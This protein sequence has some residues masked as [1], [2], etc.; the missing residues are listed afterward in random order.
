MQTKTAVALPRD[1]DADLDGWLEPFLDATGRKTRRKM[2]PLYVRGLLGGG[3]R[4]S[5]QPMAERLGLPGHDQLHH[6]ISSSAWD[7]APLWRGLA[8]Q[9]DRAGGGAGAVLMGDDTGLPKTGELSVGGAPQY[10]GAGGQTTNCQGLVS[11][12]LARGEVPVPVGLQ[13]FVPAAWSNDLERCA[14]A[15]VPDALRAAR[16]KPA[17]ALAEID[18]LIAAGVRF[19]CVLA[20]AGYGASPDFRRGLDRR[21]LAWA[22]GVACPQ[23]VYPTTVRL[24][25]SLTPTGRPAK[26]PVPSRLPGSVAALLETQRWQRITWRSGSKGPL[27]ARFAALRVRVADGPRNADNTRLPGDGRGHCPGR[28]GGRM[29]RQRRE[30]ILPQQPAAADHAAAAGRHRQGALVLRAGASAAQAR[31]WPR[32]LR[33]PVLDRPAPAR[34]DDLHRFCL[35]ATPALE[36][37]GAGGKRWTS[38]GRRRSPRCLRSDAPSAPSCSLRL[39]SLVVARTAID[40]FLITLQKCQGRASLPVGI[41]DVDVATQADHVAEAELGQEGEQLLIAEAAI[42]QDGDP[43]ATRDEVGQAAQA[44]IFEVVALLREL[45]LPD[46]D[47]EQRRR[48]AMTTDQAQHQR[49]LVVM[50]EVGPVHRHQSLLARPDL[51]RDPTGKAL[52]HVDAMVAEQP[53]HLL[54][55]MLG[56]QAPSLRQRLANHRHRQRRCLHHPERRAR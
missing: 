8:E 41:C 27:S 4:K 2:A 11:L 7:D 21:G 9:A 46:A 16:S 35:P 24:R 43:A 5:I 33:G 18:R 25:P 48:A 36:G 15:G 13:L 44:G 6:F 39:R 14:A 20:D 54:D 17:I 3:E 23:L 47:P 28:A 50:V 45:V 30:E 29:A 52:P 19:G 56:D 12:T 37:C 55:R 40:D 31:A 49:G 34:P 38:T 26:H 32:R 51:M 1:I 42:G 53:V 10:C 22:V